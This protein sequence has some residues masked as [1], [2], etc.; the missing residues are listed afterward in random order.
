MDIYNQI[1]ASTIAIQQSDSQV[2]GSDSNMA[3]AQTTGMVANANSWAMEGPLA[4][5]KNTDDCPGCG[6][7]LPYTHGGQPGDW[8]SWNTISSGG[9]T[10]NFGMPVQ[11]FNYSNAQ[12]EVQ[13]SYIAQATT[14][15]QLDGDQLSYAQIANQSWTAEGQAESAQT[16]VQQTS[17]KTGV[18]LF[19]SQIQLDQQS[20]QGAVSALS[21]PLVDLMSG[22]ANTISQGIM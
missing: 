11:G 8:I 1:L 4:D 18:D 19:N 2:L 20:Q 22:L 15:M 17:L 12:I 5:N 10:Y 14:K 16:Q 3:F 21:N 9:D 6:G 13:I 7:E